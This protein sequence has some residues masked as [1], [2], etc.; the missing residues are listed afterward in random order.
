MLNKKIL[1]LCSG[2]GG[3]LRFIH[4]ALKNNWL[5]R[6]SKISVIADRECPATDYARGSFLTT[7][8]MDFTQNEQNDLL[9][10]ALLENPDIIV[11]TVHRILR[12]P[13]LNT[14]DG[15][16]LNLHYS[17]LP[18]FGGSIGSTPVRSALSY[19]ACV[20]GVTVHRVTAELDGGQPQ[21][22]VAIPISRDDDLDQTI[23]VVF[24]AGC[25]ALF[26]ALSQISTPS[27][28]N[29]KGVNLYIKDRNALIN[30]AVVLPKEFADEIFWQSLNL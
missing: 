13:L 14:F 2:G 24:R 6:W 21:V 28:V 26:T 1:F 11:T 12:A 27:A 16:L 20:T 3:N 10:R 9:D 4:H 25:I 7:T 17:L 8:C 22:Q 19:G 29:M 30:P 15:R 5:P 23:D 18:S